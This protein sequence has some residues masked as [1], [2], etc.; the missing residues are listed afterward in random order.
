MRI[1]MDENDMSWENAWN[2]TSQSVAYTNHT[3]MPE[4]L[5]C[6]PVSL[7]QEPVSYTHLDRQNAA[8]V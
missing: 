8:P 7:L 2:I 5:E 1:L 6:W 4:A 3:V